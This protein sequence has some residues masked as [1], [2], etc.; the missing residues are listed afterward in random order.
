MCLYRLC[1]KRALRNSELTDKEASQKHKNIDNIHAFFFCLS[2]LCI[3]NKFFITKLLWP[4]RKLGR[5]GNLGK[6]GIFFPIFLDPSFRFWLWGKIENLEIRKLGI[7]FPRFPR[8]RFATFSLF[9]TFFFQY[10]TVGNSVLSIYVMFCFQSLLKW[11]FLNQKYM[12]KPQTAKHK[13]H[14]KVNV[15]YF[16]SFYSQFLDFEFHILPKI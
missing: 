14:H 7:L 10:S 9:K 3:S 5:L 4:G 15:F 1:A 2:F 11:F 12:L 16:G 13:P 6:L 8:F